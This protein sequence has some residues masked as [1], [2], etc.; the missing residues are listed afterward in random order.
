MRG[1]VGSPRPWSWE[2]G[3]AS[4]GLAWGTV[5]PWVGTA[6]LA[7]EADGQLATCL[8]QDHAQEAPHTSWGTVGGEGGKSLLSSGVGVQ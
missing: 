4:R 5:L 1:T 6:A 2:A 3:G 7:Q 8:R